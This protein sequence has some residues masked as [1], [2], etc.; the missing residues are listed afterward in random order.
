MVAFSAS[1]DRLLLET[2]DPDAYRMSV[3]DHLEELRRRL[4][5]GLV[6][7]GVALAVCLAFGHRLTNLFIAP[8]IH[9]V[10]ARGMG[11]QMAYREL[12]ETFAV[13]IKI[14]TICALAFSGPWLLY[15]FWRFVAAGLYTHERR[16]VT[17]YLP[18]SVTLLVGGMLFVYFLVLPWT[19]GF[20][21]DYGESFRVDDMLPPT[22]KVEVADPKFVSVLQGDPARPSEGQ[23][24]VN[25]LEH[26]V[27]LFAG[28]KVLVLTTTS[29]GLLAPQVTLSDYVDT[30]LAMLLA[31]GLSFQTP[32]LV[33]ALHRI[34][35]VQ[36]DTLKAGR[37]YVYLAATVVAAAITPGDFV[38]TMLALAV[39][40]ALLFEL[41]ISLAT[42][43]PR[44][45]EN[46]ARYAG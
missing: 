33:L 12:A 36:I 26:A 8:Y 24:W 39:P 30:V 25:Q 10:R 13:T 45:G 4:I 29:G 23:I 14:A 35:L 6:G 1:T 31:F 44:G 16:Y 43:R 3:G 28:K 19:I 17:R 2:Y 15:Q 21:L 41:G 11:T 18:L 20:L 37:P 7:F 46:P 38:G 5:F 27:K 32:L 34:G 40:L 42:F 9:A 22:P